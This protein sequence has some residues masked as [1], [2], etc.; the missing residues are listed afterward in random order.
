MDSQYDKTIAFWKKD[1]QFLKGVGKQRAQ[2]LKEHGIKTFED[3]IEYYP[4]K[5]INYNATTSL[6]MI[7]PQSKEPVICK[8]TILKYQ[9]IKNRRGGYRLQAVFRDPYKRAILVWFQGL[10]WIEERLKSCEGKE[11]LI[12]GKPKLYRNYIQFAHPELFPIHPIQNNASPKKIVPIYSTSEKLKRV[13]L[14][15]RGIKK[16][17]DNLL[18][19]AE[20]Y[21]IDPLPQGYQQKLQLIDKRTAY[22]IIH[23]PDERLEEAKRR[24]KFDEAFLLM[25]ILQ[26]RKYLLKRY[27]RSYPMP[28]DGVYTRTFLNELLPFELT[29][30]Q[31]RVL[32]EIKQDIAQEIQM[33]R[34]LQGDVGSGKTI[35]ALITML[36][37]I[38]NGFQAALMA[39][40]EV[41]AE[42]H[43]R[44]IVNLTAK[45]NLQVEL[46]TGHLKPSTKER[47]YY[48]LRSGRTQLVIGTH[49]L[50]ED[51]V[52][53]K[54]LGLA[55]IDEQHKFGVRQRAKLSIRG[56]R[57]PHN[58]LMTAT[59]IPRT[60]NM[61]L[62]G[63]LDVSIL[64]ELPPGRKPVKTKAVPYSKYPKV[65]Q[66]LKDMIENKGYQAYIV[67]PL[68]DESEKL[69]LEDVKNG[70]EFIKKTFPGIPV[71][72]IHGKMKS[73]WKDYEMQRFKRG[74][75][76]ILVATTVIEVGVDVPD[77]NILIVHNAQRFGLSQL[78]QLRGRVGRGHTKAYAIL[79]YDEQISREAKHRLKVLESTNNGFEIAQAD[80]RLRGPGELLGTKQSGLPDFKII[81][82]IA[83][84][85]IFTLARQVAEQMIREDPY[86]EQ[87]PLLKAYL[88]YYVERYQLHHLVP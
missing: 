38:D 58:L 13:G 26:R 77:A 87:N 57:Q 73:Q 12:R 6:A 50:I 37:A 76:K 47:I 70:F 42:Q 63:D 31:K 67:Y 74:E 4:R 18:A 24:L 2:V 35:V 62:Y 33:N 79:L 49:A 84:T 86:F 3:L 60:L 83:D 7:D 56:E 80:L 21:I 78:H 40:T 9:R 59:P 34:L 27:N 72:M 15:S 81:D 1:I 36:R 46:L 23:D 16:L 41:L 19:V 45:M 54:R 51:K 22:K 48:D 5:F 39:P 69:P 68:V 75:T 25:L 28:K 85:D 14:D 61:V 53:F 11:V 20:P 82:F 71:G 44:T 52:D 10:E 8:G 88:E 64:D 32:K 29:Q 55:V 65:L 30:A 66:W 43:F 17:I